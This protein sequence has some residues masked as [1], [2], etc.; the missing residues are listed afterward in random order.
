MRDARCEM[1]DARCE[2]LS[3]FTFAWG[4]V[5]HTLVPL[6]PSFPMAGNTVF[7]CFSLYF[8]SC[9]PDPT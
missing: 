5:V 7:R 6:V 9:W 1:R 3:G 8:T 4:R 2:R